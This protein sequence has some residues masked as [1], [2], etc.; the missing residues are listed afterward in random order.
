MVYINRPYGYRNFGPNDEHVLSGGSLLP[1]AL[2]EGL[3]YREDYKPDIHAISERLENAPESSTFDD[4]QFWVEQGWKTTHGTFDSVKRFGAKLV[5]EHAELREV[6]RAHEM[7][8]DVING[9]DLHT[10]GVNE[11]GDVLWPL[12][13]MTSNSSF[14]IDHGVKDSL[15]RY[16]MGIRVLGP[17]GKDDEPLWRPIAAQL[18]TKYHGL[19]IGDV[20]TLI[21]TGFEPVGSYA[22]NIEGDEHKY[23]IGIHL[24]MLLTEFAGMRAL[25]EQQYGYGDE[26]SFVTMDFF[27]QK[28]EQIGGI[29]GRGILNIAFIAKHLLGTTLSEVVRQNVIKVNGRVALGLVDKSDGERPD[30]V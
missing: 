6:H 3:F 5:E 25:A 10:A 9:H 8:Q 13:A 28:A 19:T 4:Y 27:T 29:G 26:D 7:E 30:G 17:Y 15:Y 2:R 1:P 22:M 18:A 11:L 14:S 16:V 23:S 24:M 21:D 12:V 20:D